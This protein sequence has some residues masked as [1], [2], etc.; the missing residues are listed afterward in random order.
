MTRKRRK[1]AKR[2]ATTDEALRLEF[3]A[4]DRMAA[5]M[6]KLAKAH[7]RWLDAKRRTSRMEAR[8]RRREEK[9]DAIFAAREAAAELGNAELHT[10]GKGAG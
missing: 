1:K 5:A 7:Q 2:V 10:V 3:E 4:H 6:A 9:G 8:E